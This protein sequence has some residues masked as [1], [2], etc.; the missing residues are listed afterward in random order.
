[1]QAPGLRQIEQKKQ[2]SISPSAISPLNTTKATFHPILII[3]S[4][5]GSRKSLN[6]AVTPSPIMAD[7]ILVFTKTAWRKIYGIYAIFLSFCPLVIA[8]VIWDL[9]WHWAR[10]IPNLPWLFKWT[11]YRTQWPRHRFKPTWNYNSCYC[12]RVCS[13]MGRM[14]Q[15]LVAATIT[16][17][18]R[19]AASFSR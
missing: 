2:L 19:R 9:G 13:L 18:V 4:F 8:K 14:A 7:M 17:D 5:Q 1:M 15:D 3:L 11:A 12:F 6:F 10:R 16:I